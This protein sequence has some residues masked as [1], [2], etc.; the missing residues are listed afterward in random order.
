LQFNQFSSQKSFTRDIRSQWQM[1]FQL[2]STLCQMTSQTI[3]DSLQSFYRTKL[4][5]S[6]ALSR[7]AFETQMQ[8]FVEHFQRTA[9]ESYQR[10][11]NFIETNFQINQFITPTNSLISPVPRRMFD[12]FLRGDARS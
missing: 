11:L 4:V 1:H 3:E 12:I 8:L 2:L 9:P 6:H 5:T 7:Q 10:T